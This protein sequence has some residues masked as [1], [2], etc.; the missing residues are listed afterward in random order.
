ML[1]TLTN[2]LLISHFVDEGA[3]ARKPLIFTNCNEL[4]Y[5][6]LVAQLDKFVPKNWI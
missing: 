2:T 4:K 6:R 3:M 5:R 1:N